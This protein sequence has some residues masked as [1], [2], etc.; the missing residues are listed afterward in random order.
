MPKFGNWESEDN[1]PYTVYFDKARKG[2]GGKMINPNDPQENP[3]MFSKIPPSD[4]AP[5]PP[6]RPKAQVEEPMGRAAAARTTQDQR[7]M[8]REDGN[9]RQFAESPARNNDNR[10][11]RTSGDQSP[12]HQQYGRGSNSSRSSRPSVG[13]EHSIDKSPLHPAYQAKVRA[14]GGGGGSPAWEGGKNSYDSSHGTTTGKSRMKP[15]T[16][17]DESVCFLIYIHCTCYL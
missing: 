7:R 10:S 6:A 2:R 16:Q 13:S 3:E 5:V 11:R 14:P 4:P 15:V 8:N 1:V 12:Y 9:Y 17:P